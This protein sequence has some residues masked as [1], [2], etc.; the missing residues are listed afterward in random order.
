M[1]PAAVAPLD[2]PS[3]DDVLA[4]LIADVAAEMVDLGISEE[5]RDLIRAMALAIV[6]LNVDR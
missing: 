5:D 3:E 6:E 1:S 4:D 2:W